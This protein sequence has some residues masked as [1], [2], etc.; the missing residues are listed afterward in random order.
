MHTGRAAAGH[1]K[2][3]CIPYP[4]GSARQVLDT[5]F[6]QQTQHRPS[7]FKQQKRSGPALPPYYYTTLLV[8][9]QIITQ[10]N[11]RVCYENVFIFN[12]K[13]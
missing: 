8:K 10:Q 13:F 4:S 6:T 3:K 9:K 2:R 1:P 12:C 5:H 11:F 7:A